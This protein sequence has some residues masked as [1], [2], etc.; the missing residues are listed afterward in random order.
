MVTQ[1]SANQKTGT[2]GKILQAQG[3][4]TTLDFS[5]ATY[6]SK[7]LFHSNKSPFLKIHQV[8]YQSLVDSYT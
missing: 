6:P 2:S 3:A 5:T 1:N 7:I 8:I 4:G